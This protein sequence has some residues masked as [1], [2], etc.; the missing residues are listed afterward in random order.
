MRNFKNN[1]VL[2][3]LWLYVIKVWSFVCYF[4]CHENEGD[5]HTYVGK[6]MVSVLEHV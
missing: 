4:Q 2:D 1:T 3:Q 6:Q 5:H